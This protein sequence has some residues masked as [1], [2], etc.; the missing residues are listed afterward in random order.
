MK[1]SERILS[2]EH[3]PI[4]KYYVYA[5]RAKHAGRKVYHLNIGQPDIKTPPQF[6]KAIKAFESDVLAYAPSE[7]SFDLIDSVRRY[8]K[9]FD[10]ELSRHNVIITHGGSEALTF[11]FQTILDP[12]DEVIT[13]EP[14]Y[15]NYAVF[16]GM[17]GARLVPIET[18][19]E[20][21][22]R[23]ADRKR[24]ERLITPKTK[25]LLICNPG[26]PTGTVLARSEMRMICDLA[27]EHDFFIIADEVYREF[28]YDEDKAISFG[29]FDDVSDRV[30][31]TDSVSKRFSACGARI[32]TMV[33]RNDD[34]YEN[35]MKL[36]QA[37][38]CC[39]TLDQIGA[40]TLYDLPEDFFDE[41][42]E[43]Y[44]NR[45]D[46]AYKALS[47]IKGIVCKKPKG[48][49]YITCKLP[50]ED[51]DDFLVWMLTE[52]EDRGET[53]MFAPVDNFYISSS[54]GKNEIRIAYIL[55]EKD[56]LRGIELIEKGLN[57]YRRR[58]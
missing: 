58:K 45:R 2:M 38:L 48:A 1:L 50:V 14:Y 57:E 5:N 33:T 13:P 52:F 22:Y 39:P 7:G 42:K 11:A 32:G 36:A 20:E 12:G 28:A 10:V 31:I 19:A 23:Y 18:T 15:T 17:T 37:R 56:L 3:S 8:Y 35:T 53:A 21:G 49:F 51:T 16:V 54:K 43:E 27:K 55:N 9:R 6:M 34:I 46:A 25:A 47:S 29:E 44:K 26:N 24:I 30:I 40:R 4:E 41:I